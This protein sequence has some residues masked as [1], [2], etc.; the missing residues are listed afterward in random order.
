M[1]DDRS[2]LS[3]M[4]ERQVLMN[5]YSTLRAEHLQRH[6]AAFQISAAICAAWIASITL[7]VTYSL[8]GGLILVLA[9]PAGFLIIVMIFSFQHVAR[10]APFGEIR[11]TN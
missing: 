8:T 2:P 3:R 7:A 4:E 6:T 11:A 9:I 1:T 5:E 10:L